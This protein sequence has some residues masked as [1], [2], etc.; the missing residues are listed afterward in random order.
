MLWVRDNKSRKTYGNYLCTM[1]LLFRDYLKHPEMVNDF[2]FPSVT[3][4]PKTLPSKEQLKTFFHALPDE[5]YHIIFLALVSSGLRISELLSTDID[6]KN[7]MLVP[8]SHDGKNK[9]G[10]ISFYNDETEEILNKY[11]GNPFEN[12]RNTVTHVFK[13]T[14]RETGINIYPLLLRS[15]FAREMSKAGVQDRFIDAFCGRI[16]QSILARSYTDYS[17]EVLKEIY[18]KTNIK[19]WG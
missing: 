18:D 14:A 11:Q 12:S 8:K 15:V 17:P 19:I 2:K 9:K 7:R 3:L 5:K 16:P 4:R 6:K 10:W 1:K 13:K